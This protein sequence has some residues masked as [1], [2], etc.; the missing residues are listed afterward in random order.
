V[1]STRPVSTNGDGGIDL[2]LFYRDLT[3]LIQCKNL[4]GNVSI[5]HVERFRTT[6]E[7]NG[8]KKKLGIFISKSGFS[9]NCYDFVTKYDNILLIM[10]PKDIESYIISYYHLLSKSDTICNS[11]DNNNISF[12]A[13]ISLFY[14]YIFFLTI[15]LFVLIH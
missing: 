7:L 11:R 9:S 14:M 3:V 10:N 4:K 2:I 1:N 5:G 13:N 8:C 15:L 12:N 6:L